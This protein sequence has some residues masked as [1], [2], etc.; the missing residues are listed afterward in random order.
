MQGHGPGGLSADVEGHEVPGLRPAG[1]TKLRQ[2]KGDLGRPALGSHTLGMSPV[3]V[4]VGVFENNPG[5]V[6]KALAMGR[7]RANQKRLIIYD[8]ICEKCGSCV[9][10]CAQGAISLGENSAEVDNELCIL[11]GY[12][13]DSCPRFAIRVV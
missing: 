1:P 9:E 2:G 6:K 10:A 5:A 11:C 3:E 7:D 4:M 13:A 8:F 12:C